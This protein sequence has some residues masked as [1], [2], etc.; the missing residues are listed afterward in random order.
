MRYI[1]LTISI[2]PITY[3]TQ[4]IYISFILCPSFRI[5]TL[6]YY[7]LLS[8]TLILCLLIMNLFL[9]SLSIS[10]RR[11]RLWYKGFCRCGARLSRLGRISIKLIESTD[12]AIVIISAVCTSAIEFIFHNYAA[13]ERAPRS[14]LVATS[15]TSL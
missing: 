4:I 12:F 2:L 14:L 3:I 1:S 5:L 15:S 11:S 10:C 13:L 7:Y 6:L 9:C 8:L